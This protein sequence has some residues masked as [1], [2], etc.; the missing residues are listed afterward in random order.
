VGLIHEKT[1]G[2]KSREAVPLSTQKGFLKI[3]KY[4]N[5]SS[6]RFAAETESGPVRIL[7][8]PQH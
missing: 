7:P 1:E 3:I 5:L 4:N 2:Q 6:I 8:E